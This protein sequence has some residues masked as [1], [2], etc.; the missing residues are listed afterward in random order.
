MPFGWPG[1]HIYETADAAAL[2]RLF[3]GVV[4][5]ADLA[6][7]ADRR[8]ALRAIGAQCHLPAYVQANL[9][10]I[11]EAWRDC[12]WLPGDRWLIVVDDCA[13]LRRAEPEVLAAL[14]DIAQNVV[15]DHAARG[16]ALH[17]VFVITPIGGEVNGSF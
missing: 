7:A 16:N 17:V 3:D 15:S 1:V 12:S 5:R 14:C 4:M 13:S 6:G 11:E 10:S 8:S 2:A 9:D